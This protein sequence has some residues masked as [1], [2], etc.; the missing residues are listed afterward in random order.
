[1][2]PETLVYMEAGALRPVARVFGHVDLE[3]G[4]EVEFT[5]P[6]ERLHF[7]DAE[8]GRRLQAG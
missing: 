3:A 2:G 1:M 5:V 8:T 6:R 4:S 7:F